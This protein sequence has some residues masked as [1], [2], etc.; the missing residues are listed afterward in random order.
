VFDDGKVTSTGEGM[1]I[2]TTKGAQQQRVEAEVVK[3]GKE[4]PW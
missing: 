2:R 4:H 3:S 1:A